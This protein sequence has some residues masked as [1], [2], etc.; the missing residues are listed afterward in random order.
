MGRKPSSPLLRSAALP[1][2]APPCSRLTYGEKETS[3]SS[4]TP[5]SVN[6]LPQ[7]ITNHLLFPLASPDP[8]H[9]LRYPPNTRFGY[10][11]RTQAGNPRWVLLPAQVPAHFVQEWIGGGRDPFLPGQVHPHGPGA[12]EHSLTHPPGGRSCCGVIPESQRGPLLAEGARVPEKR[13]ADTGMPGREPAPQHT[14]PIGLR[15]RPRP[16]GATGEAPPPL[17]SSGYRFSCST[18]ALDA[19]RGAPQACVSCRV[20][21]GG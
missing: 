20:R 8:S 6:P 3:Q 13:A 7:T 12:A 14:R 21:V 2:Q 1:L 15:A 11:N 17:G 18:C 4:H 9:H 16:V 19:A 10:Q 5:L